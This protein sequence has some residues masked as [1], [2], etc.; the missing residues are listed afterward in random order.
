MGFFCAC[1]SVSQYVCVY[2]CV[3]VCIIF[4]F[5]CGWVLFFMIYKLGRGSHKNLIS[6]QANELLFG[7]RR[8]TALEAYQL[9]LVSHVFWP[10]AFMQEVIPRAQNMASCSAKVTMI[11]DIALV[12]MHAVCLIDSHS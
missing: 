9:G 7:G 12:Q 1:V 6:V 2:A 5:V 10:T 3:C 4:M 8:I 11:V